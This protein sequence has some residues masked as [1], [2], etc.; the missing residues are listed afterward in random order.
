[1]VLAPT[2]FTQVLG[3]SAIKVG[4]GLMIAGG[5]LEVI[6]VATA[7]PEAARA[8]AQAAVDAANKKSLVQG[9][10][11]KWKIDPDLDYLY[12]P[13]SKGRTN[14]EATLGRLNSTPCKP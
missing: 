10:D 5:T 9:A 7:D 1:M 14:L 4:T 12:P 2:G 6:S 11:G 3:V 13:G 8:K